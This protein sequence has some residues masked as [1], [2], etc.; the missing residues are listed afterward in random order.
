VGWFEADLFDPANWKANYPNLAFVEMDMSDGYWGAKIVTAF[1]DELI[2][3]LAEAGEY[4]RP[5]VTDYV[6]ETF[7]RR[8]NKIGT[9]W[10]DVVTPLEAF[11]LDA[12]STT[13]TLRFEDIA[14]DRGYANPENRNYYFEVKDALNMN[15]LSRGHTQDVN[16]VQFEPI[17]DIQ[18]APTDRWGRTPL[19]VV[20]ITTNRRVRARVAL[21]VRVVIGFEEGNPDPHVLGWEHAPKK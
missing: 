15:R 16:G 20:E 17:A 7:R 10:L 11:E 2:R 4:G 13:W 21:P 8:R 1:T 9:Y 14:V 12:E 3:A 19:A 6:E 18:L 5:E